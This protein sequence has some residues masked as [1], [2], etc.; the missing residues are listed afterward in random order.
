ME[1]VS[2][3]AWHDMKQKKKKKKKKKKETVNM[4]FLSCKTLKKKKT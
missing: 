3:M 4:L 2:E 1:W